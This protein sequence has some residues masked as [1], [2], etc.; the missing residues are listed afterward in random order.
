MVFVIIQTLTNNIGTQ[1]KKVFCDH[2]ISVW[3]Q[4]NKFV[5]TGC[6]Q[7]PKKS[8]FDSNGSKQF[9]NI[10]DA[11]AF[12]NDVSDLVERIPEGC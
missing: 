9:D 10:N 11:I 2:R 5:G 1:M 8:D 6:N 4:D 12:E 7:R 3:Q